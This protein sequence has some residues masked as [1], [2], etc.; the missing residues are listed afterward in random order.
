MTSTVQSLLEL[1]DRLSDT[2]RQKAAVEIL[3]RAA[4]QEGEL[5][6]DALVESAASLFCALDSGEAA[7]DR[8]LESRGSCQ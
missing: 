7:S 2:D 1:F 3:R 5:L 8:P 6:E 4:P